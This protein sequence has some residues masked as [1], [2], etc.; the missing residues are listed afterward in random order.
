MKKISQLLVAVIGSSAFL[1][2]YAVKD[3]KTNEPV[4]PRLANV[5]KMNAEDLRGFS[6]QPKQVRALIQSALALTQLDLTYAFGSSNPKE[7]GMDCSGTISHVLKFQGLRD[8]PRQSDEMCAW[9]RD[10]T[11][12]H[13]VQAARDLNDAE[14]SELKPG[15][16]VFWTGTYKTTRKL[17]VTHVMLYLGRHGKT[18]QHL[19]FGSSDG[20]TYE[21]ERL[22][23]VSV[24]DFKMPAAGSEARIYGYGPVPG[25]MPTVKTEEKVEPTAAPVSPPAPV[26]TA[27]PVPVVEEKKVEVIKPAIVVAPAAPAAPAVSEKPAK[28]VVVSTSKPKVQERVQSAPTPSS[29]PKPTVTAAKKPVQRKPVAEPPS[30]GRVALNE[31][32]QALRAI[33]KSVKSALQQ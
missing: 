28:P 33:G 27:A 14:F 16:L 24:F 7:G 1:P 5:V 25:L 13:L 3:A 17:P 31:V 12:L 29:K 26:V 32:N 20:R 10:K 22:C 11:R 2:V 8:V 4:A 6:E 9:V 21:G 30:R 19:L 15:D 18:G 23:G